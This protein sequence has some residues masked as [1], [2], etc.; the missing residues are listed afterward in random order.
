MS[1][2]SYSPYTA[3]IWRIHAKRADTNIGERFLKF[4]K[5]AIQTKNSQA[6]RSVFFTHLRKVFV[7]WTDFLPLV[8]SVVSTSSEPLSSSHT[9]FPRF[10]GVITSWEIHS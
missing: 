9:R 2:D 8:E 6:L 10:I 3:Q 1:Q 7:N 5:Q 4:R